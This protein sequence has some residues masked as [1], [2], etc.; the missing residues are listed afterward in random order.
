MCCLCVH[1]IHNYKDVEVKQEDWKR[2]LTEALGGAETSNHC[3]VYLP[4]QG[5]G[6]DHLVAC[7]APE[8][9]WT[10]RKCLLNA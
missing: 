5:R 6:R 1:L 10:L 4:L 8:P 7:E 9:G 2:A 3:D